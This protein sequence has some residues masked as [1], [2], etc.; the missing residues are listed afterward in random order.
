M[1]RIPGRRGADFFLEGRTNVE[2][3]HLQIAGRDIP[4]RYT[5]RELADM[6]EAIGTMDGFRDLILKGNHRLRNMAT[7]IRIMGN[8]GLEKA[9]EKA[10]LTDDWLLDHMDPSKLKGYQIAVLGAF[11]DGF[12]MESENEKERDLVLE[13]L[14]RKKEPGN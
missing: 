11:T 13:E 4:L 9:G 1:I 5:M 7:A 12:Q 10:D 2:K 6:E 8:S 14:E 3:Y